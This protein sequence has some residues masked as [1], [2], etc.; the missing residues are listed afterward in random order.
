MSQDKNTE[1]AIPLSD[2]M[3]TMDIAD[4]IRHSKSVVEKELSAEEREKAL[5]E[6]VKS[7]YAAQGIEVSDATIKQAIEAI[8]EERFSYK[9]PKKSLFTKF[10][11]LYIKRA[12]IGKSFAGLAILG[13]LI[14]AIAWAIFTLPKQWELEKKANALNSQIV[15]ANETEDSLQL[16][17]DGLVDELNRATSPQQNEL[18]ALFTRQKSNSL[19]LLKSAATHIDIARPLEQK[20]DFSEDNYQEFN[21]AALNKLEQQNNQL[22]QAKQKLDQAEV[23]IKQL[24]QINILP[25]EINKLYE[26]A[27]SLSKTSKARNQAQ[28]YYQ[29]GLTS[30]KGLDIESANQITSDLKD[31]IETLQQSY[32]LTVVSRHGEKSGLW[33]EPD[34]NR[35]ARNYYIVVEALNKNGQTLRLPIVN[36]ETGAVQRVSM[37]ALRVERS[38]YERIGRDKQDDGIVQN[39][40]FGIKKQGYLEVEYRIATTGKAITRW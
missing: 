12:K 17:L 39:N 22:S 26:Q 5:F 33:R 36:E 8:E 16:R 10:A 23:S 27:I 28:S 11:H 38:V 34:I 2:I 4:N 13:G 35:S 7:T 19:E 1:K 9:P 15:T 24:H 32:Q 21:L 30:I 18:K 25:N 37:W 6:K 40:I 20:N 14:W 31:L 3:L 29:A